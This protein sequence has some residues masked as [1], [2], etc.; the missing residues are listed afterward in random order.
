[1]PSILGPLKIKSTVYTVLAQHPDHGLSSI[2]REEWWKKTQLATYK[3]TGDQVGV[4]FHPSL[5][6]YCNTL[7]C[8][9]RYGLLDAKSVDFELVSKFSDSRPKAYPKF[10]KTAHA[11]S[12]FTSRGGKRGNSKYD[13]FEPTYLV[14][15]LQ[16]DT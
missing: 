7:Q 4:S 5:G 15:Y 1:M 12:F 14:I 16:K 3:K 2:Q 13:T 10:A 9:C 8:L 6:M 11:L